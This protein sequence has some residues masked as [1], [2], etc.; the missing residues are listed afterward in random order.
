MSGAAQAA[1]ENQAYEMEIVPSSE[2]EALERVQLDTQVATAKRW[3]RPAPQEIIRQMIEYATL[4]EETATSCIYTLEREDSETREMK[5]VIGPSIRL[6][7]IAVTCFRNV[8]AGARVISNNG[9]MLQSQGFCFDLENNVAVTITVDRQIASKF[10]DRDGKT[11]YRTWSLN[12]QQTAGNAANSVSYRNSVF[13]V[14]PAIMIRPVLERCK[15]IAAGEGP[16]EERFQKA[17]KMFRPWGISEAQLKTWLNRTG[18]PT[19]DLADDDIVALRG[20]FTAVRDGE[21]TIQEVFSGIDK[22]GTDRRNQQAEQPASA[23]DQQ[24]KPQRGAPGETKGPLTEEMFTSEEFAAL[25]QVA[26]NHGLVKNK[27]QLIGWLSR[28]TGTKD[29]AVLH[30]SAQPKGDEKK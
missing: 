1:G 7:E 30:I 20:L 26:T 6:A 28:W 3:P 16:I 13:K 29:E 4:D 10:N 17:A 22:D 9:V 24:Q 18:V 8:R 27:A 25:M 5:K 15:Q 23:A 21:K 11:K 14:I 19:A 12:M 2:A